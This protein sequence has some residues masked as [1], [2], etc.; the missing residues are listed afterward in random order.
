MPRH[1]LKLGLAYR[2]LLE[3]EHG[4]R[5]PGNRLRAVC[6]DLNIDLDT[7]KQF[8]RMCTDG[9]DKVEARAHKTGKSEKRILLTEDRR[10]WVFRVF[11]EM[12]RRRG[13]WAAD[14]APKAKYFDRRT[15]LD[16]P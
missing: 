14:A 9:G 12:I 5:Q 1:V 11:R 3:S 16:E 4:D 15:D 13:Q 7:L 6:D 10:N 8:G 2:S